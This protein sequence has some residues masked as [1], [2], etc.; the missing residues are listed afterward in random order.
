M[1][2]LIMPLDLAG[3][4]ASGCILTDSSYVSSIIMAQRRLRVCFVFLSGMYKHDRKFQH[5]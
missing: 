5:V 4:G 1:L 3:I 2:L